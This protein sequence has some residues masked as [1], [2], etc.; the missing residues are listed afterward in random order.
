MCILKE[1][2]LLKNIENEQA[3]EIISNLPS[4]KCFKKGDIIYSA[5]VYP[6]ALG[7]ILKGEAFAVTNNDN[8][9][10]MKSFNRGTAFGA[11]AVFGNESDFVSTI[12]AKTDIEIM[13][14]EEKTLKM[15]FAKYPQTAVNYIEFLSDKIRF[16]NRK[17]SLLS[18]GSAE[19]TVLNY[20]SSIAD[21]GGNATLPR[22]M[23]LLSRTIGISRA[24]LYRCIENLEN[25]GL[26]LKENNIIKVIKN[27]KNS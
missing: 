20:F 8:K 10:F 2:F 22:N 11:A 4:S 21:S 1:F 27:E 15:I 18:S 17:V 24:S 13:F 16:L 23:T 5:E 25:R 12:T 7:L 14:I 19:N 3:E 6:N 9:L 26:I